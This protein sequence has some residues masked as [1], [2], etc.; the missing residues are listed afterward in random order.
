MTKRILPAAFLA[1]ALGTT[2]AC[3]SP[4]GDEPTGSGSASSEAVEAAEE[5]GIDL[6]Q[7]P[8]D[9]TEPLTG[10]IQI[11]TTLAQ[12]GPAA[13]AFAP[14]TV[15]LQAAVA[16]LNETADLPVD[17][18]LTVMDDQ[19]APERS[20]SGAQELIQS[21]G[22]D[23]L[24]AVI[25]T[26][27]VAAVRDVAEQYCV[28]LIAANAGGRSANEVSNF[29]FTTVWSLPSYVDVKSWVARME[30]QFPDGGEI[31]VL[32]ANN[33]TGNDYLEAIDDQLEGTNL[34]VVSRTTIEAN[35]TAPPS[36]QV[37][38]MRASGADILLAVPTASGQCAAVIN[39]VANAGWEP[40][41]FF[42]SSQCQNTSLIRPAGAA[43]EGVLL[44]LYTKDPNAP[45]A[46]SDPDVQAVVA[47]VQD[48][49]PGAQM[50]GSTMTGYSG[51]EVLYRAA[52]EAARSP[53]GLSRLGL[54][55]AATHMTFEPI[56]SVDGVTYSTNY[57]DDQVA[58][59]S[60]QLS[61]FDAAS[62]AWVPV[63]T[64]DFDGETTGSA[65]S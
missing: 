16:E 62:G 41:A 15:G 38:T 12:T 46:E 56:T 3:G 57:P 49:Q 36:S 30:S 20:R 33:D 29:P 40:D 43:A 10:T 34:S 53:L 35:D 4:T 65:S 23:F 44:N 51:V 28:P 14:V 58:M 11:G 63:E 42:M 32:T 6:S 8:T 24:V 19:F 7:C 26:P 64:F 25:G 59:E 1:V 37:A 61:R 5:L 2:A 54:L 17:F 13:V 18:E 52:E 50:Y 47:A 21:D 39:E 60:G 48:Y 45:G 55:Y 27:N 22:V 9:I 31:A